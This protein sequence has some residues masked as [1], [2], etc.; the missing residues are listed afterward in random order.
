M[1]EHRSASPPPTPTQTPQYNDPTPGGQPPPTAPPGG[2]PLPGPG[3]VPPS[4]APD[5]NDGPEAWNDGQA[6]TSTVK[7]PACGAGIAFDPGLGQYRC[8]FCRSQ[9]TQDE[10]NALTAKRN[11]SQ[12]RTETIQR[13]G[14]GSR[15]DEDHVHGYHC[16]SCGAEV[17]TTDTTTATF[18]YYCHNPVIITGRLRGGF[19]PDQMIPFAVSREQAE[20]NFLAWAGSKSLVPNDFATQ[21]T[22]EKMTGLYLPYW[23]ADAKADID[24]E[25]RSDSTRSW[26]SGN[27]QYTETTTRMHL[28]RGEIELNDV[29]LVAFSKFDEDLLNGISPYSMDEAQPFAMPMLSGFFAEQFDRDRETMTEPMNRQSG[30]YANQSLN[31]SL[32]QFGVRDIRRDITVHLG[33]MLYTL[34]P[35]WVL[36]YIYRGHTYVYAMNAQTGKTYGE[37]PLDHGKL[38]VRAGIVAAVILVL[39]L[40]GGFFI[41]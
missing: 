39:L 16:Q 12:R 3:E 1:S 34:L 17:V 20:Q 31:Q 7:C 32:Q 4:M 8:D 25:G 26:R 22:L 5:A 11:A 27:T 40:V 6:A 21:S 36:T 37:L 38:A 30:F 19:L 28:R 13:E 24:Y 15:V 2:Q 35:T 41:W 14:P 10:M 9:F 33:P 23:Y 29:G 18:C